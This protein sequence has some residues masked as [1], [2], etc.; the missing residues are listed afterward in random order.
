MPS[1]ID[2]E[3][4]MVICIVIRPEDGGEFL[5]GTAVHGAQE[6]PLPNI[7]IPTA[8]DGYDPAI[9]QMKL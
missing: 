4:I 1:Q 2:V 5:A 6:R 8:F 9:R 7:A 3:M